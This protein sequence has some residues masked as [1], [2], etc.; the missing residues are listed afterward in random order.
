MEYKG[1][2]GGREKGEGCEIQKSRVV[3]RVLEFTC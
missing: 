2:Q 1:G 3:G